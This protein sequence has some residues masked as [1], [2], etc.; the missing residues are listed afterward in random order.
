MSKTT[1]EYL[2]GRLDAI[3][4]SV[5]S[6]AATLLKGNGQ[7][8]VVERLTRVEGALTAAANAAREA[9]ILAK[10]NADQVNAVAASV[11]KVSGG[12]E[13][14]CKE[15]REYPTISKIVARNPLRAFSYIVGAFVTG[16]TIWFVLYSLV[17][18]PG[19]DRW[20]SEMLK[21]P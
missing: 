21:L 7:P 17:Q 6:L 9:T 13:A 4:A 18:L 2:A 5:N 16:T 10:E 11:E 15:A 19:V 14:L 1:N 12:L 20:F 3:D 8:A